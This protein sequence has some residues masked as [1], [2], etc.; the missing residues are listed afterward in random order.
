ML[1]QFCCDQKR[2]DVRFGSLYCGMKAGDEGLYA[3]SFSTL[4]V[5]FLLIRCCSYSE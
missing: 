4:Q 2:E 3:V 5:T 1:A